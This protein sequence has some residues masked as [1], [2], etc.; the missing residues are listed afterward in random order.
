VSQQLF[1]R[2]DLGLGRQLSAAD[3]DA[4]MHETSPGG[5]VKE[6]IP[7]RTRCVS[8]PLPAVKSARWLIM[9]RGLYITEW[10]VISLSGIRASISISRSEVRGM[11]RQ[12]LD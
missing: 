12:E 8:E 4:Y 2:H 3:D 6:G 10:L 9:P 11:R 7:K 1:Q 5:S